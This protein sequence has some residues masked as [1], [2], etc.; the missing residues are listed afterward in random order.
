MVWKQNGWFSLGFCR[1]QVIQA[2]FFLV[3]VWF[4]MVFAILGQKMLQKHCVFSVK[5]DRL[6]V[7][8]RREATKVQNYCVFTVIIDVERSGNGRTHELKASGLS[9]AAR[10][11]RM[12]AAKRLAH[13]CGH[14]PLFKNLGHYCALGLWHQSS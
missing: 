7:S 6:I 12:K 1:F 8:S 13:T 11:M 4:L 10:R 2:V 5:V 9:L 3:F 14:G